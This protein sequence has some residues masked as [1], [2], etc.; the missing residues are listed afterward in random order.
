MGRGLVEVLNAVS[1]GK[2]GDVV[3]E[4][5]RVWKNGRMDGLTYCYLCGKDFEDD[6]E[7][8]TAALRG[9]KLRFICKECERDL[10]E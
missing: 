10:R 6:E 4:R 2:Y 1:A 7:I 8:F 5:K 9:M 3:R